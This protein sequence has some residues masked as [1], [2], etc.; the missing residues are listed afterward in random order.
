MANDGAI[1][2]ARPRHIIILCDGT[3]K[4]G[5]RDADLAWGSVTNIWRLYQA[6]KPGADKAGDLCMYVPG[7][8]SENFEVGTMLAQMFGHTVVVSI[9]DIYLTIAQNY[10]EGDSINLFGYS[11]GAFIVR[12]VAS[13]IGV[14]GLIPDVNR[15]DKYLESMQ[16]T[17]FGKHRVKLPKNV[18]PVPISCIGVWDTVGAITHRFLLRPIQN[19]LTLPDDDLPDIVQSAL[20][21]VAYHENRKNFHVTLWKGFDRHIYILTHLL[22]PDTN[23]LSQTLFPG[24]H[25]DIGG[26][27]LEH[28]YNTLPDVTLDW[29]LRHMP[30][31]ITRTLPRPLELEV[32]NEYHLIS[33][34]H[35]GPDWRRSHD[36]CSPRTYLINKPGL[37]RHRTLERL[38]SPDSPFLLTHDW[39]TAEQPGFGRLANRFA[40]TVKQATAFQPRRRSTAT[41]TAPPVPPVSVSP[42]HQSPQMSGSVELQ[43]TPPSRPITLHSR[44]ETS[45]TD[46]TDAMINTHGIISTPRTSIAS[47]DLPPEQQLQQQ[48]AQA[49]VCKSE[50]VAGLGA[51]IPDIPTPKAV[52]DSL[53]LP[54]AEE[55]IEP[56]VPNLNLNLSCSNPCS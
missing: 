18:K 56:T 32:P 19:L 33:A 1:P 52:P 16:R 37:Y 51:D 35:D 9:R 11:R 24:C 41:A 23:F 47:M 8:G 42:T 36:S 53:P 26:G 2:S 29:M 34:F 22:A 43:A 13:L 28:G 12:K 15:F 10:K 55:K 31:T 40:A 7:V 49:E 46:Q 27:G 5:V 3:G 21:A 20:H 30:Q 50:D 14:L 45:T 4:N 25:S 17:F 54:I 44:P 48:H 39:E 38:P 6:V